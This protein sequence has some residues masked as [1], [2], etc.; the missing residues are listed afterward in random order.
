MNMQVSVEHTGAGTSGQ[1]AN[2]PSDNATER[3]VPLR[4]QG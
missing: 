2:G 3:G 1:L 4:D